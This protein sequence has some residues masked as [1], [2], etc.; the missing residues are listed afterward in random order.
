M[1]YKTSA[2]S[3]SISSC[4]EE[5]GFDVVVLGGRNLAPPFCFYTH[6]NNT[7]STLTSIPTH[8]TTVRFSHPD[9]GTHYLLSN[10]GVRRGRRARPHRGGRRLSVILLRNDSTAARSPAFVRPLRRRCEQKQKKREE[11]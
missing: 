6:Q 10:R 1:P 8:H 5:D 11:R 3:I 4:A 2:I 7:V 9:S